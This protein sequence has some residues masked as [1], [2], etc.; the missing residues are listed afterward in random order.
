MRRLFALPLC[1]LAACSFIDDFDDFQIGLNSVQGD[2]SLAPGDG[3]SRLDASLVPPDGLVSCMG[4]SDG[5]PCGSGTG[6]ICIQ[7]VCRVS[8]CGDRYVD[9]ALGEEC[10]D[11]NETPGDGCEPASCA[12]SCEG[13]DDCHDEY[14]CD[15]LETCVDHRCQPGTP[16]DDVACARVD[17]KDGSCRGGYCVPELC[18]NGQKDPDEECDGQPQCR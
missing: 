16:M 9:E 10:D 12:Y 13:Q 8:G 15:G 17:G 7:G 1:L 3:G 11:G 2:A 5:T 6:L 18:G 14:A 4:A